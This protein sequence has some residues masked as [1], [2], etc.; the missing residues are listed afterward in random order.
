MPASG[1][2]TRVRA[3][4]NRR[5]SRAPQRHRLDREDHALRRHRVTI[6]PSIEAE[7]RF[8]AAVADR[9]WLAAADAELRATGRAQREGFAHVT[10]P[11]QS[12]ART[13]RAGIRRTAQ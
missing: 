6:K 7:L 11:F 3:G 4:A 5:L 9:K 8:A 10:I 13:C 12:S 2:M 1:G